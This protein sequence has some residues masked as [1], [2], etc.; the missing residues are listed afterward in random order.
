MKY[1]DGQLID[2]YIVLR[3][4]KG[5]LKEDFDTAVEKINTAMASIENE[6][7]RR[8]LE[9]KQQ[10]VK[11]ESGAIAYR[12]ITTGVQ[13]KDRD[14]WFNFLLADWPNRQSMLTNAVS[15]EAVREYIEQAA[16]IPKGIEL[17]EIEKVNFRKG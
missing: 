10:S 11:A 14:S 7:L 8:M 3:G 9:G 5:K 17:T 13:V 16:E 4:K 2:Q 12:S 1:T 15:K 6:M